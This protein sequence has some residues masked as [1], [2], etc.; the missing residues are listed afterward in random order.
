M[1]AAQFHLLINHIPVFGLLIGTLV[2]LW[3]L[4]FKQMGVRQTGLVI[5]LLGGLG[6]MAT[7]VSGEQVEHQAVALGLNDDLV[8]AHE[9]AAEPAHLLSI[10]AGITAG[11]GLI[12]SV[13]KVTFAGLVCWLALALGVAGFGFVARAAH[14]GGLIKHPELHSAK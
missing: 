5:L 11:I 7:H 1:T 12:L 2:L 4:V 13:R 14:L 9:E 8:E 3:G 6:E 10:L